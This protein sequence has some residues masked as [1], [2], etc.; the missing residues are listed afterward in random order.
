MPRPTVF[1]GSSREQV[2]TARALAQ[3]L[4]E[5]STA[6]VWEEAP[7]ELNQS[8]FDGLL[9]AAK[10]SDYAVFVFE[11]DDVAVVRDASV[12]TV[13]DNVLFE[14]GLFVGRIG[15]ERTFWISSHRS[16]WYVPTDLAGLTHLVFSRPT[17]EEPAAL[18]NALSDAI[19]R[20]RKVIE[21]HGRRTDREFDELDNVRAL[22]VASAEYD[23]PRFAEDIRHIRENFPAGSITSA[24]GV[25][26]PG[27]LAY[28]NRGQHWDIVHLAMYVDADSGDLRV[29]NRNKTGSPSVIPAEGVEKLMQMSGPRLVV[30]VT[31]DSLALAVRLA[32]H[33]NTIAGHRPID[34]QSALQW[35]SIFYPALAEGCPLTEAFN[36]SQALSDPG[37]VLISK[38]DFR[39]TLHPK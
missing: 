27:L 15:R 8:I 34:V 29:P 25:D 28:F 12:R 23:E 24:H 18:A 10:D 31:C 6:T 3:R 22:C 32:R 20:L 7:F 19:E 2:A 14:F 1:I 38:R 11:P 4:D 5:F 9:L 17:S 36:R 39:L 21:Q 37:L 13:R 33:A 35:S 30:V 26:A 16:D